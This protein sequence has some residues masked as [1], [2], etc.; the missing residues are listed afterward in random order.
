MKKLINFS[1][2]PW[3]LDKFDDDGGKL[4]D[5]LDRHGL[6]G[7]EMIQYADWDKSIVPASR[8]IGAHSCFW[9]S[10][11]DF[12]REDK[13]SLLRQFGDEAACR[14]YYGFDSR[15]GLVAY[16]RN[17]LA[18]AQAAGVAYVVFHVSHTEMEHSYT[19]RFTYDDEEVTDAF[20]DMMNAIAGDLNYDFD[21]LLENHWYP[22]LT[23]LDRRMADKLA[24]RLHYPR[25]GFVLDTGH[26]MNTDL[27]L[28][29]EEQAVDYILKTIDSLGDLASRIKVIHLNSSLTGEYVKKSMADPAYDGSL[30]F[31][32]RHARLYE[33]ISRIDTHR[34]FT[35]PSIR[36]VID[37]IGPEYIVYEFCTGALETLDHYIAQQNEALVGL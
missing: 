21:I 35:D 31:D 26:L 22:G 6:D 4:A 33:H 36:R 13:P 24:A 34:P 12:W 3:D 11:L 5:F 30:A 18:K 14:A 7:V 37:R 17:E 27:D 29:S 28:A 2:D 19:Y 25:I 1:A 15:E 32:D 23:M 8:I 10:W 9:P 20:I 16:Y